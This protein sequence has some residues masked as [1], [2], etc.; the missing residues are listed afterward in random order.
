MV[1]GRGLRHEWTLAGLAAVA[2]ALILNRGAL[3]DPTHTLPR[4]IWDPS[5]VAYLIAWLGYA[6]RHDPAHLWHLNTFYPAPYGLAYSDALLGYAPFGLIGTGP[7][8]ALLRYNLIYVG[9]YAL[10][11]FGGYCLA[12]QLGLRPGPAALVGVALAAAPWRL[13][14]TGHLQILSTG[15]I[16]LALA[17]LA[18]GHGVRWV[19]PRGSRPPVRPG[20]A[21]A[22]WLGATWQLSIGFGIGLPFLYVL[23]GCLLG[24]VAI[25]A[26]RHRSQLRT[27]SGWRSALP[28]RALLV[29]DAVGGLIFAGVALLLAQ[30]YL[31]VLELYPYARRDQAWVELYSPPV[32]G[33]FLAPAESTLWGEVQSA[34]RATLAVPG[35]MT[36]LPG[37]VLY[38]LA[39]IGLVVSV[40]PR[41]VRVGLAVGAVGFAVL[42]LG[43]NGPLGGR[44]GYLALLRLPGFEA[45]RTPG[46]LILWV[47]LLLALLAAGALGALRVRRHRHSAA[48]THA[49]AVVAVAAVLV[50]GRGTIPHVPMPPAPPVLS[51]VEAPYLVLPTHEVMDMNVMLWSADRFAPVVNGGSGLVP[52]ELHRTREAVAT[53]PDAASVAY[54]REIGVRTVVV[55]RGRAFGTPY[56]DADVVPIDHLPL[57]RVVYPDTVV[58]TLEP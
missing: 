11:L 3:A 27:R 4:D 15:G 22:G 17:M 54:L 14:Q 1:L 38:G 41:A 8:A 9:A 24:G 31:R 58:F 26:V 21:F 20:W 45:I 52:T 29:A 43:T 44:L 49:V 47:T 50:E 34:A 56:A 48:I 18:R 25:W 7:E 28:P 55:L 51:T 33:L 40:W 39:L 42:S 16:F 30:P 5:L 53:F 12:R 32:V 36:L 19:R 35:E 6:L 13:A 2:L 57:T 10:V 23:L 46:R 37:F